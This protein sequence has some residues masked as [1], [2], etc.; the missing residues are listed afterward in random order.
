MS[1]TEQ[2]ACQATMQKVS[3]LSKIPQESEGGHSLN[4]V[5]GMCFPMKSVTVSSVL[6]VLS[7]RL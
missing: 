5:R 2:L 7:R 3:T 4:T 1:D 6:M